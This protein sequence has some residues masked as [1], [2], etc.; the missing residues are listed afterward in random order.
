MKP[1]FTVHAG[2]YLVGSYI[3]QKLRDKNNNKLNVWIPSKDA[4]IDLL[5]TNHNNSKTASIQV[6]FSKDFLVAEGKPHQQKEYV[7]WGWWNLNRDKIQESSADFWIFVM[8][9]FNDR[10]LQFVIITSDLL[11]KRLQHLH[12]NDKRIQTYLWVTAKNKCWE[13]RGLKREQSDLII[14]D[15]YT[16]TDKKHR[17]FTNYLNNWDPIIKKL[18]K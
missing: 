5:I 1:I 17:N 16:E 6:K 2:E 7:S 4:G 11:L 10:N 13:T 3:E 8:N 18:S 12:P 14:A 15:N 9:T